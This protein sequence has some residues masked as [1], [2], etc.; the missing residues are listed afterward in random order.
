MNSGFPDAVATLTISHAPAR[1]WAA[2][3]D[4]ADIKQYFFGTE[5]VTDWQIGQPIVWRGEWQGKSFEDHGKVLEFEPLQRFSVTHYSPLT[6][7]PDLPENYHTVTYAVEPT[8]DGTTLTIRQSRNRSEG[9]AAESEKLWR[10]VLDNL[11][12]Y[13]ARNN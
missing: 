6:G 8:A 1:V 3:T 5:V 4:P 11:N 13:L 10:M 7:L 9:E 12:Q 2:I